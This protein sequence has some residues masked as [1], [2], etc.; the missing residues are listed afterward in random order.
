MPRVILCATTATLLLVTAVPGIG[1][2]VDMTDLWP[3]DDG[4]IWEYEQSYDQAAWIGGGTGV[5]NTIRFFFNG[6]ILFPDGFDAVGAT[7][8]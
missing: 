7:V 6:T 5:H 8:S 1:Q 3:N 2:G 4:L